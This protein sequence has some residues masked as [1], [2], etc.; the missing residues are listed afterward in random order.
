[1]ALK[2]DTTELQNPERNRF[3]PGSDNAQYED[4]ND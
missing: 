4:L 3:N 1:M 2:R